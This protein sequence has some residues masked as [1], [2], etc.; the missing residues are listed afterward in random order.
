MNAP[1]EAAEATPSVARFDFAAVFRAQYGRIA[2]VIARVV[3]D[4]GRAEEL[5]VE[6]FL[7]LWRSGRAPGVQAQAWLYRSAVR[8]GLDELR[9]RT[10]RARYEEMFGF[11]VRV[12]TPEDLHGATQEKEKVRL[13]LARIARRQAEML[14]LRSDGLSYGELAEALNLNPASVGTLLA[15]AQQA[16][17]KEYVKRYGE[18]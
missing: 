14:L 13:V 12:R 4:P 15:R 5:A 2:R 8:A 17:R 1:S 10:R 7:K 16:F 9:R 3:R 6:V 18:Q 11:G